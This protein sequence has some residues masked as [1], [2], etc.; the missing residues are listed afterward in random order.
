MKSKALKKEYGG[1][2]VLDVPEMEFEKGRVYA[3][4]GANGSGKT[5]FARELVSGG[6]E[7]KSVR[8]GYMPQKNYPFRMSVKKNVLLSGVSEEEADRLLSR[9]GMAQ[10]AGENAKK[11]SGGETAKLALA[12]ILGKGFDLL[13]LDEPTASMDVESTLESE[14]MIR[15]YAEDKNAAV[16]LITHSAGQ[17]YR[18]ADELIFLHKGMLFE[19]GPAKDTIDDPKT[20]EARKFISL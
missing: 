7:D 6:I 17:A 13:I 14:K 11:L 15:E 19:K 4:M 5:T 3:V 1:R 12:R 8:T 20:E 9:L 2:V 10:L 18:I 16:I